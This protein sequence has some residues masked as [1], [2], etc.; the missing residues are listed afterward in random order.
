MP[1]TTYSY[2]TGGAAA[3]DFGSPPPGVLHNR[4]VDSDRGIHRVVIYAA[5]SRGLANFIRPLGLVV[6]KLG[7]TSS[8][9]AQRR[10]VDLRRKQYA[11]LFGRPDALMDAMHVIEQAGEWALVPLLPD[12]LGP[13]CPLPPGFHLKNGAVEV[14]IRLDV[15]VEAVDRAVHTMMA[16]R[17]LD[18][19][20]AGQD[21]KKRL[22]GA[23]FDPEGILQTR[24]ALM[25]EEDRISRAKELYLFKPQRELGRL[26]H[27]LADVL[28]PL[29]PGH[30]DVRGRA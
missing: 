18:L 28:R 14:E 13:G 10:V 26:V 27:T 7:V 11:S 1:E 16:P 2:V 21:G 17:S 19:F 8:G 15:S 23:G 20:L 5:G 30:E 6:F 12:H 29:M 4:L 9:D 22:A 24:Y 3:G 25:F